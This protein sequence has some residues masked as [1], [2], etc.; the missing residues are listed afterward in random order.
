M[1]PRKRKNYRRPSPLEPL[2]K[3]RWPIW[4]AL[5][6]MLV[7]A[8]AGVATGATLEEHDGFCASCHT[9]PESTYY[10]RAQAPA[11]DLASQH[12]QAYATRCIDCHSGPG[13][14]GRASAML[15]GARDLAAWV[16]HTD[17]QPAPQTVPISDAA[18]LKCHGDVPTTRNF[19]RHFHAFLTRWQLADTN[20]GTCV[21]CHTGHSTA[22]DPTLVFLQQDQ[23]QQ[24]CDSCHR[25]LRG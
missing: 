8:G 18:C 20:A 7:L 19:D 16:T 4:A 24:V 6:G 10:Q 9:Q 14:S 25:V 11:V 12:E 15:L 13:V 17:Q 1:P 22:G 21:S 2:R 5:A 23:T 3:L